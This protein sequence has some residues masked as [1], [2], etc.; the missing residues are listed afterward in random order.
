M[1]ILPGK[2]T[3]DMVEQSIQNFRN[4]VEENDG[5]VDKAK[6]WDYRNFAYP[7]K[8]YTEGTYCI[9]NFASTSSNVRVIDQAIRS[10]PIYLRYLITVAE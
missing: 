2:A 1:W 6:F 7:I 5:R 8:K 9:A 4:I 3:E 10:M